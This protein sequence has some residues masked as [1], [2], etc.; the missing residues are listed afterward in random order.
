MYSL[1][2]KRVLVTGGGGFLGSYVVKLLKRK[3]LRELRITNSSEYDLRVRENCAKVVKGINI[4]IHLAA[5]VGGIGF[6]QQNPATMVYDNLLINTQLL[7]AAFKAGVQKII[8]IGS[9]CAY[10]K[11]TPI[12]F[13]VNNIWNGY[14]EGTNAPYGLTKRILIIQS[15]AYRQQY[16]FNSVVFILTNLY[17]PGQ[18]SNLDD[19]HVIPA[20]ITKFVTAKYHKYPTVTIWGTGKPTREFLYAS[21]AARAIIL[22]AEKYNDA[23]PLNIGSGR[24][25]S[26]ADLVRKIITLSKYTGKIIWDKSRPDGQPRRKLDNTKAKSVLNFTTK[27]NLE[28]G[29]KKTFD[30]YQQKYNSINLK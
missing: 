30:W 11:Y 20:L 25:I 8:S 4:V 9:V 22:G 27:T 16:G 3:H 19:S 26:I 6:N 24:E 2:N 21:D 7:D 15:Q 1:T 10:P 18:D 28:T 12:P 13:K 5:K 23:E 14:P 17:G 29:L